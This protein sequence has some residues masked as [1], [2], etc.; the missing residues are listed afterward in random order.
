M[1]CV[2][3]GVPSQSS[4]QWPAAVMMIFCPS[5][6]DARSDSYYFIPFLPTH[7]KNV[8]SV[9]RCSEQVELHQLGRNSAWLQRWRR[10]L[11]ARQA[12][13]TS[14]LLNYHP[15]LQTRAHVIERTPPDLGPARAD[16]RLLEFVLIWFLF[17][18]SFC[19]ASNILFCW[20]SR[21]SV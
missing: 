20:R 8:P 13:N 11:G 3:S 4:V 17:V 1:I 10:Q 14:N 12:M 15:M 5:V 6:V 21:T 9:F 2:H 18:R 7:G 19:S 16:S